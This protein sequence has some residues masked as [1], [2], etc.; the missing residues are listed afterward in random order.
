MHVL[1]TLRG[2]LLAAVLALACAPFASQAKPEP[3]TVGDWF[4]MRTAPGGAF[5]ALSDDTGKKGSLMRGCA[6]RQCMW[7][8]SHKGACAEGEQ[9]VIRLVAAKTVEAA[10]RCMGPSRINTGLHDWMFVDEQGLDELV[11]RG[12]RFKAQ[13]SV[14]GDAP[15]P[16]P[17]KFNAHGGAAAFKRLEQM[18]AA[19]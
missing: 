12:A 14:S 9:T 13:V 11:R 2:R 3:K 7:I 18:L 5:M 1:P 8:L 10:A 16:P 4:I 19:E 17:L 15:V 6:R